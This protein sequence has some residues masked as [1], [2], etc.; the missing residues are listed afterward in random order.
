M[1]F[2]PFD[3]SLYENAGE[4]SP[5]EKA[6]SD[7]NNE[8]NR[9]Y[10]VRNMFKEAY[11]I[12]CREDWAKLNELIPTLQQEVNILLTRGSIASSSKTT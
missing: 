6:M 1:S 3:E 12:A 7:P 5:R 11:T 2:D 10:K 4:L 9:V 8:Y